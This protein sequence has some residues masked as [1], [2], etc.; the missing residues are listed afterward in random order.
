MSINPDLPDFS[1]PPLLLRILPFPAQPYHWENVTL[2]R[3]E[4]DPAELELSDVGLKSV[5]L[6]HKEQSFDVGSAG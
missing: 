1:I 2:A 6:N 5:E 4:G 3:L